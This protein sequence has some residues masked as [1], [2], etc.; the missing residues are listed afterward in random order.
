MRCRR[1]STARLAVAL[2]GRGR[3]GSASRAAPA[4]AR[5]RLCSTSSTTSRAWKALASDGVQRLGACGARAC[6]AARWS[7]SSTSRDGRLCR[8]RTRPLPLD[9]AGELRDLVLDA[10]RSAAATTSRSSSSTRAATTSG[11]S[12]ARTSRSPATG[13]RSASRGGRSSSPGGRRRTRRLRS[14]R[15]ASSSSSAPGEDGGKGNSGSIGSRSKRVARRRRRQR[16]PVD[17]PLREQRPIRR[18]PGARWPDR[19]TAW[20]S[21]ARAATRRSRSICSTC[22]SSAAS[23]SLGARAACAALHVELSDDG[24]PGGRCAR[25]TAGNGGRDSHLLP[26]AEARFLRLTHAAIPAGDVG[27]AEIQVRDL[28]VRRVAERLHPGARARTRAAAAIR[29]AYLGRADVLD[30][31]R[32]RRRQ[33][34][35]HAVGGRR[36][37][38][39]QGRLLDR[40]VRA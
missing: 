6:R 36:A 8:R 38:G 4:A 24:A 29:A 10:R 18:R 34:R 39:A 19:Q 21:A 20:R 17:V 28:R 33:R 35:E 22:A 27:I 25:S 40:A 37:R 11:G 2:L 3:A 15:G 1:E 26:E 30:D 12:G 5:A 13:S 23:R 7:W 16:R 32:R 31:R 9:A 14:I